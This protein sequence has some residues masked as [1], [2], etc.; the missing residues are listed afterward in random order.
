MDIG[1]S[2]GFF[3]FIFLDWLEGPLEGMCSVQLIDGRRR[4]GTVDPL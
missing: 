3:C 4:G 2:V 1:K